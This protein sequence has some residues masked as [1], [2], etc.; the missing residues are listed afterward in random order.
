M[1]PAT[2]QQ[3]GNAIEP[4]LYMALELSNTTWKVVFGDGVRR[5]RA[6]IE[7]GDLEKLSAAMSEAK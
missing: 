1:N 4:V 3:K 2:H 5:R 6:S 7:A